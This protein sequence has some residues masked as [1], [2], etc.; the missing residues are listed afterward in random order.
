ME[1]E[2]KTLVI[3]GGAAGYFTAITAA[4]INPSADIRIVEAGKKILRKVK[5]SGG[6]RCNL[7][8]HCFDPKELSL[9]YPRGP[10][11]LRGAFHHWQPLDTIKWFEQRGVETKTEDDGRMFPKSNSSQTV[12]DCLTETARKAGIKTLREN[13]LLN[14]EKLHDKWKLT[15]AGGETLIAN[16][17]C[18]ALGSLKSSG[19]EESLSKLG[20]KIHPSMPSLFS[21]NLKAHPLRDLAGISVQNATVLN[22]PLGKKQNGPILITHRGLSGPAVLRA[23]AWDAE[24]LAKLN[25][26]FE[27]EIN[28]LGQMKP[29]DLKNQLNDFRKKIPTQRTSQNPFP[30][31]PKRLWIKILDL[32]SIPL[33]TTWAHLSKQHS[34]N[35]VG[36][37]LS[38]RAQVDG[39]TTNKDEF[40]TC[41]G[42]CLKE[43]DFKT[44]ESKIHPGL[45]FAGECLNLDGITGGFNFQAAWTTG[46]IAGQSMAKS[47][48]IETS[49]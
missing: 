40:V 11:E 5:I 19:L 35:L 39:K 28:W 36:N 37:L 4:E 48:P 26:R 34:R 18:L 14:I 3:G 46:R 25:Y 30:E 2:G 8:H 33:E 23:S 7:T 17:V 10:R 41:G 9:R 1:D 24:N 27:T 31:L 21:F 38:F 42:I 6:G 29:E 16:R 49:S 43:V 45:F 47:Y 13:R 15:L 32:I 22:H 12:I 20:H 44:M